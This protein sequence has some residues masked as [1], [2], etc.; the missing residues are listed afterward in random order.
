MVQNGNAVRYASAE[1]QTTGRVALHGDA[2]KLR[3]GG[4]LVAALQRLAFAACFADTGH[5]SLSG[6]R[7]SLAD[8]LASCLAGVPSDLFE[9]VHGSL[10]LYGLPELELIGRASELGWAWRSAAERKLGLPAR[11]AVEIMATVVD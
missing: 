3:A 2:A 6:G 1:L 8:E 7:P 4:R 11:V 5:F 9:M 10:V